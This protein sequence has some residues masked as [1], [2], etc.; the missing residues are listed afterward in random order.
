MIP[1][2]QI[3]KGSLPSLALERLQIQWSPLPTPMNYSKQ[4]L[5][6]GQQ[7]PVAIK[8]SLE[9]WS[10]M[11]DMVANCCYSADKRGNAQWLSDTT[12]VHT[13]EMGYSVSHSIFFKRWQNN[14]AQTKKGATY[15]ST[16]CYSTSQHCL[17]YNPPD[18]YF[19]SSSAQHLEAM[20]QQ[21]FA[22]TLERQI[23]CHGPFR[24]M[25]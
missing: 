7:F 11:S 24:T 20:L 6:V 1:C 17:C 10:K 18:R 19:P 2:E 23:F 12:Q 15:N 22:Y 25:N 5:S 13:K 8:F 9:T 14:A 3:G 21:E 4:L 16:E